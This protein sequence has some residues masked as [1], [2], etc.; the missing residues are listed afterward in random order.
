VTFALTALVLVIV[1]TI[2]SIVPAC[3]GTRIT[4]TEAL[5]AE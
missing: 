5:R 1:A 3:R 4:P 2:A